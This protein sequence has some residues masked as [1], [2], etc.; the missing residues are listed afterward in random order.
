MSES[1]GKNLAAIVGEA[2]VEEGEGIDERY[3]TAI[4]VKRRATPGWLARPADTGEVAAVVRLCGAA[5]VPITVV[6][7]QTGTCGGAL[8]SDGG[9]ALSLERMN[10]IVEIDRLSMTM[11]LEAGCILQRAQEA[12]EQQGALLPLDLG[13]R[14]SAV[15]GG[16]IGTN[17][18]GNRVLRWGMMRDMVLGLEAVLAD[19]TVVSSLGK[20]IKDNAGYAWKHLLIG[21]EGTLGIVTRAVLRLRPLPTTRQTALVA[22]SSFENAIAVLRQ[23]EIALSGQLSSFEIM[24]EDFYRIHTEAQL[25]QRPRP[26]PLGHPVYALIEAMGGNQEADRDHFEAALSS[27]VAEGLIADA[28]VAQSARE[29]DALW[30]VREDLGPG[31]A[32]LRPFAA[33]DVSMGIADMP[34][35]V[36]DARAGVLACYPEAKVLFY[37][38]AGDG[39]LHV[40]VSTGSMD[41]V[42]AQA[43]NDAIYGA[44]RGVGGSIAAEHG[45]GTTRAAY[46]GWTRSPSELA[47]MRTI[48]LALDPKGILNPGKLFEPAELNEPFR[49]TGQERER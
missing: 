1:F 37:G 6:G 47:L 18:G 24:W 25:P 2:F 43:L 4:G 49:S 3:R 14:G 10:R 41:D 13:A 26:M 31:Y 35:F 45:I 27:L 29:C 48:R 32:P 42:T 9:L 20:M 28:V 38:H 5:V 40:L 11:T 17:A 12:A 30:A 23:L 16:V 15:I 22:A 33:Y 34:A 36:D 39:N 21:S 46:L 8:P 44:V 19:G 7:G